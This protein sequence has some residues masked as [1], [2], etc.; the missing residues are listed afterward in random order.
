MVTSNHIKLHIILIAIRL[1][2]LFGVGGYK[3]WRHTETTRNKILTVATIN[4]TVTRDMIPCHLV[5]QIGTNAST[6]CHIPED[7]NVQR[8]KCLSLNKHCSSQYSVLHIITS[9]FW[10]WARFLSLT[11]RF[12]T[13]PWSDVASTVTDK[14]D[15]SRIRCLTVYSI[16]ALIATA[17]SCNRW[18]TTHP[19]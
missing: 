7:I 9:I 1:V 16:S 4:I 3:L 14:D 15:T 17:V 19:F 10:S 11:Y 2:P 12:L 5:W 13:W 6:Q 8:W 18:R